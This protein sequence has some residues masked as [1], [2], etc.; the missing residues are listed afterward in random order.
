M[1]MKVT[2]N[3]TSRSN[4]RDHTKKREDRKGEVSLPVKMSVRKGKSYKTTHL[5][6]VFLY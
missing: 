3:L 4:V 6:T 2:F 5:N 1:D